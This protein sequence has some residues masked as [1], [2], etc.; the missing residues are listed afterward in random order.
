MWVDGVGGYLVCMADEVMLGQAVASSGADVPI[1]GD[2]S[3]HHATIVRQGE[4]YVIRPDA[5]TRVEGRELTSPRGLRDGDE[6]ELGPSFRLR[7]RQPHPL[8]ATARLEFLSHH[9]TQPATDGVL[10]MANSCILGPSSQNHVV[11]RGWHQDVVLVRNGQQ[12]RCHAKETLEIDGRE[13]NGRA[14]I[15]RESR[16]VGSDFCLSLERFD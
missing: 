11:C 15:T 3:R 9:R 4:G 14:E 2:L 5:T 10:L 6:I 1:V 12:L 13:V 16:I 7:F 8:S